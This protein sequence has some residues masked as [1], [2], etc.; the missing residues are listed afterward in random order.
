MAGTKASGS[1]AVLRTAMPGHDE[2]SAPAKTADDAGCHRDALADPLS[3]ICSDC[4]SPTDLRPAKAHRDPGGD[5]LQHELAGVTGVVR[6]IIGKLDAD[7]SL[8]RHHPH[9]K[10][11]R[12]GRKPVAEHR[13][14]VPFGEVEEHGRVAAGGNDPP[15]R[16]LRFEPILSEILLSRHALHPILAIEDHACSTVGIEQR[17][18]GGQLPELTPG[19]LATGAIT[20]AGQ[21][22]RAEGFEFHLAALARRGKVLL[23]LFIHGACPHL[24]SFDFVS[25]STIVPQSPSAA[26]ATGL[27]PSRVFESIRN[28]DRWSAPAR[29]YNRWS[30]R[31]ANAG[32]ARG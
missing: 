10:R 28:R 7:A 21:D 23:L 8:F 17:W 25:R 26:Y 9:F 16:G 1:D 5:Q 4:L 22:R 27:R 12:A 13:Q 3:S 6:Y 24:A 18:R 15:C 20:G 31:P 30:A 32:I 2:Q 14:P 19:F 11:R 29:C